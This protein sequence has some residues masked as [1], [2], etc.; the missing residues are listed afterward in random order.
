MAFS[1]VPMSDRI[2]RIRAKRDIFTSGRNMTINAERTKI[3]TDYYKA[4]E[5]E[6]PLLKRA[7]ALLAWAKT[8]Q[9]NVYD[10]DILVG[11]CGPDERSLSPYVEW[12]C[13]WIPVI[14][15]DTDENFRKAWQSHES[16]YMSDEQRQIF[17]EAWDFWKDRT[18]AAMTAGVL[19]EDFWEHSGNGSY[20]ETGVNGIPRI[21]SGRPQGHYIANFRKAINVGFGEVRRQAQ[22]KIDAMLGHVYGDQAR[23]F[24]FYEAVVRVCDAAIILSKRYAQ[25][26][27]DKAAGCADEARRAELLR[28]ADSLDWIMEHPARNYWEGLQAALFYQL[29][30]STDAQQHGQSIG[31]ID[32][33]TGHLLQKELDEGR[34]TMEQAQ[35]YTDAFILKISDMIVLPGF[36]QTNAQIIELQKK[37]MSVYSAIYNGLTATSGIN[38]TLG[39]RNADGSDATTPVTTCFLQTYG[40]MKFP[41]PT[42]ALRIHPGTPDEVWRLGI[43]SSKRCGG[44]PQMQND[45]VIIPIMLDLGFTM[46]EACDYGIVG[47]VEPGGCGNEWTAAGCTGSECMWNM[48]RMIPLTVNGGV[49]PDT[50]RVAVPCEKL[51]ECTSFEQFQENFRKEMEH[52]LDWNVTYANLFELAY[53][54]YYPCIV[55][56]A[57]MEGCLESGKDVNHGGAKYNRM[58]I[59]ATGTSNVGDSL[60]AIKKLCFDDKSVSTRDMYDALANNWEGYEWI[61]QKCLNEV[62]HYGNDIDEVD[63]LAAWGIG[64][65]ADYMAKATCAR[66]YFS[67]GTFTMTMHIRH[68]KVTPATPDGRRAGEPLADAISPRQGFDLNGPTAYLRSAAKL[69]HRA[70]TNGD[71][72]NIR[73]S[74]ASVDGDEGAAK[75]RDLINAYFDMG[76]MQVQFNVVGTE[77]L[78]KAQEKP[79][80]FKDLIVRIAGFSTYFVTLDKATQDD[81]I[82]RTEQSI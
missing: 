36:P 42:V 7:G 53:G 77:D 37:G 52:C 81:F 54:E 35:E 20:V 14:C 6:F 38:I 31:R 71:Q 3:Y 34:I 29:M 74:P 17:R 60:M 48:V 59:T 56:S 76:G 64:L 16:V 27:R 49:N 69:P 24:L 62:P 61:R 43:E 8:K 33:Y 70:L 75:L 79:D 44:I 26:C 22:E 13:N 18:I 41:D 1:F 25:A 23:T 32:D 58:G 57:L 15:D 39:G 12:S 67:G 5:N 66:G 21:V 50:G 65:F 47:C 46:E 45:E 63:Q 9:C 4:H 78:R 80:A 19:T 30:L 28:M 72:L 2:A 40:R 51:Y 55:A 82:T 73:F 11:S 10:D 68:G